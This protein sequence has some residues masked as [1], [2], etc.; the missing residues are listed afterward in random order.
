[1]VLEKISFTNGKSI[2]VYML[3]GIENSWRYIPLLG[4]SEDMGASFLAHQKFTS[5]YK[6]VLYAHYNSDIVLIKIPWISDEQTKD[7][8]INKRSTHDTFM[9]ILNNIERIYDEL[10]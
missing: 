8:R 7:N 3:K 10:T 5:I 4:S 2:Y 1:V 6:A 9:Y